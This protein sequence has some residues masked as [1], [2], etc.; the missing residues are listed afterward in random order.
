MPLKV[1]EIWGW[2]FW[3][4]P[5][6][7]VKYNAKLCMLLKYAYI[8]LQDGKPTMCQ[9]CRLV[10]GSAFTNKLPL[11]KHHNNYKNIRE[12]MASQC[13][14]RAACVTVYYVAQTAPHSSSAKCLLGATVTLLLL[15]VHH[16]LMLKFITLPTLQTS[17][18]LWPD[19]AIQACP[20]DCNTHTNSGFSVDV[21][22]DVGWPK[23]TVKVSKMFTVIMVAL[24]LCMRCSVWAVFR[25]TCA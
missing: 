24:L 25:T 22:T 16:W 21:A 4:C 7:Y 5:S 9:V 3:S 13:M 2:G 20:D 18:T 6:R 11:Q 15:Q 10:H 8:F 14:R 19:V 1:L 12:P 17:K 23:Y